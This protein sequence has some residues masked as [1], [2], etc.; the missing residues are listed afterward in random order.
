MSRIYIVSEN[1]K[2]QLICLITKIVKNLGLC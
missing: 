1:K 2:E